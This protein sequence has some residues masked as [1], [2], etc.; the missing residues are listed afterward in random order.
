MLV[1]TLLNLIAVPLVTALSSVEYSSEC[2]GK[3]GSVLVNI[4]YEIV[5]FVILASEKCKQSTCRNR[6]GPHSMS[7]TVQHSLSYP[8]PGHL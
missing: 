7:F 4:F 5:G 3:M 2:D 8:Q 1:V 6:P